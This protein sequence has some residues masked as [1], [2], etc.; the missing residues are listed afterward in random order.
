MSTGTSDVTVT[1][2]PCVGDRGYSS[3]CHGPCRSLRYSGA[4]R[5]FLGLRGGSPTVGPEG[6]RP[7]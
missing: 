6:G 7:W 3:I 2:C 5:V 4:D 1:E